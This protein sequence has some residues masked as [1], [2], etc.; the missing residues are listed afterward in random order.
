M[1]TVATMTVK[2]CSPRKERVQERP[3]A[4]AAAQVDEEAAE[5]AAGVVGEVNQRLWKLLE[6]ARARGW[7]AGP[8]EKRAGVVGAVV[9]VA[10]GVGLRGML[11]RWVPA[12]VD[13]HFSL[14]CGRA[15][16]QRGCQVGLLL[17]WVGAGHAVCCVLDE[18]LCTAMW[19]LHVHALGSFC[20]ATCGQGSFQWDT[21][22]QAL[23]YVDLLG[24][25]A[26]LEVR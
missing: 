11:C 25:C 22:S 8:A 16:K 7:G 23:W 13:R 21:Q 5:E 4:W 19:G 24:A 17:L 2:A 3:L 15:W 1:I 26:I 9:G 14:L 6:Q 20:H 18:T 10:V 12:C